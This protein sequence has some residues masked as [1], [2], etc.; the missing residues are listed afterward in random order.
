MPHRVAAD[1]ITTN[2][3]SAAR[4]PVAKASTCLP[5]RLTGMLVRRTEALFTPGRLADTGRYNFSRVGW[6]KIK[7]FD[8]QLRSLIFLK[9]MI[10]SENTG[11]AGN[12]W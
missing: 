10:Y 1:I 11:L 2:P 7:L 12:F 8:N 4:M 3:T 5:Q 6:E 9:P